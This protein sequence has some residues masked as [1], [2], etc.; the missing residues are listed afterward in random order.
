M[1]TT[2]LLVDDNEDDVLLMQR[3]M[4]KAH[5]LSPVQVLR[6]GTEAVDYLT[7]HHLGPEQSSLPM[8]MVL[9][10]KMPGMSGFELLS[11]IRQQPSL[12]RLWVIVMSHSKEQS[13]VNRAYDLGANSYLVKPSRLN[14]LVEMLEVVRRYWMGLCEKPD[15]R[16]Q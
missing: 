11:W 14:S 9:D 3:A 5:I 2:I 7:T 8:L 4:R 10:L 12:R 16:L 13:D 6:D 1:D 15:S